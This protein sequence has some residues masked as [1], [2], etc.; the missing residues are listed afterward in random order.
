MLIF[1]LA[2]ECHV[3]EMR[4]LAHSDLIQLTLPWAEHFT[5][6]AD[7]YHIVECKLKLLLTVRYSSTNINYNISRI[8]NTE[9]NTLINTRQQNVRWPRPLWYAEHRSNRTAGQLTA[10]DT[11]T[12]AATAGSWWWLLKWTR[13]LWMFPPSPSFTRRPTSPRTVLHFSW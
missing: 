2:G 4:H 6:K 8:V 1:R 3:V 11:G 12:A 5:E 13:D 10:V 9:Q 7:T